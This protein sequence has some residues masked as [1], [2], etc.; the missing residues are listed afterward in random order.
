MEEGTGGWEGGEERNVAG[1]LIQEP[2][3][4][5]RVN[6]GVKDILG[7]RGLREEGF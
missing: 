6:K 7:V 2:G 5:I 4:E 3:G 1:T